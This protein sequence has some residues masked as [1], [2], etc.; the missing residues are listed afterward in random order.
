MDAIAI[1]L[2][3]NG[4]LVSIAIF[5]WIGFWWIDHRGGS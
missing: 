1:I 5:Y 4:G 2:I 3:L